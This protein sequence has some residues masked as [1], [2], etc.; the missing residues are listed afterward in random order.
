V[1]EYFSFKGRKLAIS[2]EE[3]RK[4][5]NNMQ[6]SS[7]KRPGFFLKNDGDFFRVKDVLEKVQ[8]MR[9]LE[10]AKISNTIRYDVKNSLLR[11]GVDVWE[12][13]RINGEKAICVWTK[14]VKDRTNNFR[15]IYKTQKMVECDPYTF[16]HVGEIA[17]ANEAIPFL[18]KR[19]EKPIPTKK[20][21]YLVLSSN[22]DSL[23]FYYVDKTKNLNKELKKIIDISKIIKPDKED[24]ADDEGN[25][26]N[27]EEYIKKVDTR[28][29]SK[30]SDEDTEL[31][32]IATNMLRTMLNDE[33]LTI[34]PLDI[35]FLETKDANESNKIYSYMMN[36]NP[37]WNMELDSVR[38]I[39]EKE[40]QIYQLK[41]ELEGFHPKIWR[42][43]L[44][45]N[46]TFFLELH[47]IIQLLM[48]WTDEHLHMFLSGNYE[49]KNEMMPIFS[50]L[51]NK[52][53][54]IEYIY[55]FGDEWRIKISL[56]KILPFDR[57]TKLPICLD[58]KMAGPPEDS[59]GVW[60]YMEDLEILKNPNDEEYEEVLEWYGKDFDPEKFDINKINK[61]LR[62][63]L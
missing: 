22:K 11:L 53:D 56:E 26:K 47:H 17:V 41:M 55:D 14:Y 5:M 60:G 63:F 4:A 13:S 58:G 18:V 7:T 36:S 50:F 6:A 49:I 54:F 42:R 59:G 38:K 43:I 29:H 21:V 30:F 15:V 16:N 32:L 2:K 3:I 40:L 10:P 20:G 61:K 34:E 48:G 28:F 27:P 33:I 24:L 45:K 35:Y 44:V 19:A 46:K 9:G 51:R 37:R 1:S 62:K 8:E 31:V 25:L 57:K 52:K 12:K 23:I 39:D